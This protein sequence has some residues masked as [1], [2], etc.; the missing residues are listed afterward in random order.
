MGDCFHQS[1]HTQ[2]LVFPKEAEAPLGKDVRVYVTKTRLSY[3]EGLCGMSSRQSQ[4][5][6]ACNKVSITATLRE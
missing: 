6:V 5:C 2:Q 1:Q 4:L 3:A